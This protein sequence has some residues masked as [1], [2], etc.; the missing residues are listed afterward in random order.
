MPIN[1]KI[2]KSIKWEI[3]HQNK[4]LLDTTHKLVEIDKTFKMIKINLQNKLSIST[5]I[6]DLFELAI[7]VSGK[8]GFQLLQL[9]TK[10]VDAANRF[11]LSNGVI[12]GEFEIW[13]DDFEKRLY[14][15]VDFTLKQAIKFAE[16][17]NPAICYSLAST[18]KILV[19]GQKIFSIDDL[20]KIIKIKQ[21][22]DAKIT[23]P[24]HCW[25]VD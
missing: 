13:D 18:S 21:I 12:Q 7:E 1:D 16:Q 5:G 3:S 22:S 15:C 6:G 14:F 9:M 2:D 24:S 23:K 19:G 17:K 11:S 10:E 20:Q 8:Q 4:D 25:K